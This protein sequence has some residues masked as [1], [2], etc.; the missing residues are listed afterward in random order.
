MYNIDN[1]DVN[2][3]SVDPHANKICMQ[4]LLDIYYYVGCKNITYR[5]MHRYL[6]ASSTSHNVVHCKINTRLNA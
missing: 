6:P 2:L 5:S 4:L 1:N 3:D